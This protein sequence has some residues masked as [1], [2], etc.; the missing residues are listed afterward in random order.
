SALSDLIP[1]KASS[2]PSSLPKCQPVTSH[3]LKYLGGGSIEEA[4]SILRSEGRE[5]AQHSA[6]HYRQHRKRLA[7]KG[8]V[9]KDHA[10]TTKENIW[11]VMGKWTRHCDFLG[12]N[13][14]AFLVQSTK[15]DIM[16]FLKWMLDVYPRIRKRSS[17]YEH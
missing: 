15:K 11:R 16:T 17:L 1:T 3:K 4:M 12:K 6:D 7:K 14:L 10:D 2:T 13:R 5:V 9:K 8:T